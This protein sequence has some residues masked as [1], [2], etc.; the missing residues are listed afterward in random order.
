MLG[1]AGCSEAILNDRFGRYGP[2]A[3]LRYAP[4]NDRNETLSGPAA[5]SYQFAFNR[6]DMMSSHELQGVVDEDIDRG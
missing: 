3:E 1:H 5:F 2:T 6:L 4:L